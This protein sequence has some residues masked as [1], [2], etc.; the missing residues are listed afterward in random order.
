MAGQAPP[1]DCVPSQCPEAGSL[2]W[3]GESRSGLIVDCPFSTRTVIRINIP[4]P[5]SWGLTHRAKSTPLLRIR[6]PLLSPLCAQGWGRGHLPFCS[7]LL[8]NLEVSGKG[9]RADLSAGAG[10][11][12]YIASSLGRP[13]PTHCCRPELRQPQEL[14]CLRPPRPSRCSAGGPQTSWGSAGSAPR[15]GLSGTCEKGLDE[16]MPPLSPVSVLY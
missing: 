8:P 11:A 10:P 5:H 13:S 9:R 15:L 12:V 1:G 3:A 7:A 2:G 14:G 4:A 16:L 6:L